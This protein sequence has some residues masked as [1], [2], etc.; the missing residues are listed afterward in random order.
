VV[1]GQ[2]VYQLVAAPHKQSKSVRDHIKRK[3][4]K[5]D[6]DKEEKRLEK[7][8]ARL[9]SGWI[10]HNFQGPEQFFCHKI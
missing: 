1:Q 10:R 6:T 7:K 2:G 3:K 4:K 9:A 8:G 5:I